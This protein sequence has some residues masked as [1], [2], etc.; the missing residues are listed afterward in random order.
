MEPIVWVFQ[1]L[2]VKNCG[3][4]KLEQFV[5]SRIGSCHPVR[6]LHS[7]VNGRPLFVRKLTQ[8]R[9]NLINLIPIH[10]F[11]VLDPQID[12]AVSR[13]LAGR[14]AQFAGSS[15]GGGSSNAQ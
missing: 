9:P 7:S 3:R 13:R 8:N 2:N 10:F 11:D 1:P 14:D 4:L 15:S 5:L 12:N 6:E